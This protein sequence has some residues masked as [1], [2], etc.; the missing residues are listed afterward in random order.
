MADTEQLLSGGNVN[1][2]V[3]RIDNTVRRGQ[4]AA[5][6]GVHQ[7]LR[8]LIDFDL[9]GPGPRLRDIAYAAY[10]LTPLSFYSDGQKDNAAAPGAGAS[11][12][13]VQPTGCTPTPRCWG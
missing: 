9:A 11:S 1:S 10:W 4:T 13:S 12:C 2:E 5:S 6:P 7:L 8:H 3:V